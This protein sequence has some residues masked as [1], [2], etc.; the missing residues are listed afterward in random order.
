MA[1]VSVEQG[2]GSHWLLKKILWGSFATEV[3]LGD[4][5]YRNI[6]WELPFTEMCI[7]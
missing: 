6:A 1:G 7:W 5:G 2:L 3:L 4:T